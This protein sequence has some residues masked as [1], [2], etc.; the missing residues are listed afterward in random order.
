MGDLIFSCSFK[1]LLFHGDDEQPGT[2]LP[3]VL[4]SEA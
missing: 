3:S 1:P 2:A 4:I